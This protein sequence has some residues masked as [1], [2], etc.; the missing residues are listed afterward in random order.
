MGQGRA[1][2]QW[3]LY[4]HTFVSFLLG[5]LQVVRNVGESFRKNGNRPVGIILATHPSQ[6]VEA[7]FNWKLL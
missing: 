1:G 2:C 7:G 5:V 3:V 6:L 4:I